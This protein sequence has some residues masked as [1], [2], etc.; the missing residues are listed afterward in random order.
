M[1]CVHHLRKSESVIVDYE[2]TLVPRLRKER[3][4]DRKKLSACKRELDD[5]HTSMRVLE[6]SIAGH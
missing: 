1:H 6:K 5:A 2:H 3:S 4:A